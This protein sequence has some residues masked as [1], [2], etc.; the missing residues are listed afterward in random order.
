VLSGDLRLTSSSREDMLP[1]PTASGV[2]ML[3]NPAGPECGRSANWRKM[4]SRRRASMP[5]MSG[6]ALGFAH[7]ASALR[8]DA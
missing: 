8:Q 5:G 6:V 2:R 7:R 1:R 3:A 4:G